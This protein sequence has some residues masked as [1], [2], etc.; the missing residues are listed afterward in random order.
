M[1]ALIV[2]GCS[3]SRVVRGER[4]VVHGHETRDSVVVGTMEA[5][6]DT[7]REV[8]TV[9]IQLGAEGDTLFQSVVR[10]RE[11]LRDRSRQDVAMSKNVI[12]TDTVVIEKRDSVS[13]SER[14][15]TKGRDSPFERSLRLILWIILGLIALVVVLRFRS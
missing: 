15:N 11:R 10:D 8:T 13:I 7:V 2:L 4:F 12:R 6:R 14:S 9:T 3:S 5:V 1:V